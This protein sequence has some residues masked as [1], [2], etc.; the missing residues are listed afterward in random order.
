MA[1]FALSHKNE[2]K[3]EN[4]K[5][6]KKVW[7]KIHRKAKVRSLVSLLTERHDAVCA[8]CCL[9]HHCTNIGMMTWT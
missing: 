5:L 4:K 9:C 7:A 2:A 3:H 8:G 1:I 6:G